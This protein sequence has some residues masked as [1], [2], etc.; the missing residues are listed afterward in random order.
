M[1]YPEHLN[2]ALEQLQEHLLQSWEI[3]LYELRQ[4]NEALRL[5]IAQQYEDNLQLQEQQLR[6]K[7]EVAALQA[8]QLQKE[9]EKI[10]QLEAEILNQR[11]RFQ[12]TLELDNQQS[13]QLRDEIRQLEGELQDLRALC[14]ETQ[15]KEGETARQLELVRQQL[16]ADGAESSR[17][18]A[19]HASR[20][21]EESA[22]RLQLESELQAQRDLY[23]STQE[24]VAELARQL[25]LVREQLSAEAAQSSRLTLEMVDLKLAQ[26]KEV[27]RLR[28]LP[29]QA[30]QLNLPSL[31]EAEQPVDPQAELQRL[32]YQDQVTGLPNLNLARRY[33]GIELNRTEK[34]TVA[35]AILQLERWEELESVLAGEE[36]RQ[37]LLNQ[38]AARVRSCLRSEDVLASGGGGEF[39]VI[40]PWPTG[41]PLGLKNA[42]EMAQRSLSKLLESLR[43][44]FIV[45]DH[46]L[47]LS[48]WGGLRVC[49]G[50]EELNLV[51]GQARL[52]Q[53][54][55]RA[56]GSNRLGLFQPEMEKPARRRH[57]IAPQLRQALIRE[58]F[59][60][61]FLPVVELKTGQIKGVEALVRW[62]HPTEGVLEPGQFLDAACASGMIVGLGEW[63]MACVCEMS[64]DF[65]S[66]YWFI[67]LSRPELMQ[68]DLAR[69]L[70]RSMET[71]QLNRPDYIVVECQE[72]DL[73]RPDPRIKANLK[74][75]KN[76]KVG[77]AVDDFAFSDLALKGLDKRGIGFLKVS[78]QVTQDL[79]QIPVRNLVKGGLLA[80][81]AAG[82]RVI[83]KGIENQGQFDLAL[84][85]GCPW[86][87]G[88]R[89]SGPLTW[90][91]LEERL[92]SRQ[93]VL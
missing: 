24:K 19:Q 89:L 88:H 41:G 44:P 87:Q 15:E 11:V 60:L 71:A 70:T 49:K 51:I 30:L 37:Q 31:V 56:K 83:L 14:Q 20:A 77:L 27:A 16:S 78:Q 36:E 92:K 9:S 86:G 34:F 3:S 53:E 90:P 38:F 22:S 67:N 5:E 2:A 72:K 52:A 55:A 23:Q 85:L 13:R 73:A 6:L 57:E 58:Q 28:G 54:S 66:L 91:E 10:Q 81:E 32:A 64:R 68:A 17:L 26:E 93:S 46:K 33:L 42:T 74:E 50:G 4:E 12:E 69:R 59:S 7:A 84:E 40:F 80:A 21:E 1:G 61:R 76:W 48:L 39:W 45:D 8:S 43:S 63:V 75:L 79:D 25:E 47:L 35:L 65:R 29:E 82:A 18:A 62:D